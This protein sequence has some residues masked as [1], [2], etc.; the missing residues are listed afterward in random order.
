M[1]DMFLILKDT[2]FTG[3]ADDN[4]P[5]VVRDNIADV[6]KALDEIGENLLNLFS[7]NEMK[8]NTNKCHLLL[9]CQEPN[10]FK[11]G[12]LHITNS[13]SEK[14]LGITFDCKLKFNKHIEDTCQKASQKINALARLAPY[15]GTT[16]KRIIMNTFFKSQ[17]NYCPLVWMCCN[18][19]LNTSINRQHERCLCIV[20]ND[21]KSTFNGLL[22]KDSYVS[23]H[24]QNLQKLVVK[25]FKV[26]RGLSPKIV[27]DL[28]Q[29]REQIP[30]ELR[31]R[32]QFQVPRV[33]S[34]YSCTENLKFLGPKVWAL[35]PNEMKQSLGKF[36]NAI[37][38]WKPT[39]QTF[40][41]MKTS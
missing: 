40:V 25:M 37:K 41:L 39:Q 4:T 12:D 31:Q 13:L 33:H 16:K 18:R 32:S 20:Y 7:N 38:Q 27:N 28:F 34:V 1:C 17:F 8:L 22:V 3:Y 35:V 15:M 14:L 29:F 5:F 26:S 21:K 30:Y 11:I 2:Y 6:I 19:S 23:I 9:H 24:H 10:R 36:R